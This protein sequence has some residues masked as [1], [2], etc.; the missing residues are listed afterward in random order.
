LSLTKYIFYFILILNYIYFIFFFEISATYLN[1]LYTYTY[2]PSNYTQINTSF[3]S[4]K[5]LTESLNL[6]LMLKQEIQIRLIF[7]VS[8]P[9]ICCWFWNVCLQST[10]INIR[11]LVSTFNELAWLSKLARWNDTAFAVTCFRL[12]PSTVISNSTQMPFHVSEKGEEEVYGRIHRQLPSSVE[13]W[14]R[15]DY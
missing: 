14:S 13:H 3:H 7:N 2:F 12:P 1:K 6:P 9:I 15:N 8:F 4:I 5:M 10:N 11:E